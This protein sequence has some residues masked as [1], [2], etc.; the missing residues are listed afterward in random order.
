MGSKVILGNLLVFPIENALLYVEPLYIRAENG[1]LPELQ[2]V[3]AA[4]SDKI[5]MG[6]D[7]TSTLAA[8]F[9]APLETPSPTIAR[10]SSAA[11]QAVTVAGANG[12]AKPPVG[13][14]ATSPAPACIATAP[15]RRSGP[16]TGPSSGL[17]CSSSARNWAS[18]PIRLIISQSVCINQPARFARREGERGLPTDPMKRRVSEAQA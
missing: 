14:K 2:R 3:I 4:Y 1:Q 18:R 11:A 17:R 9:S 10:A 12:T 8:L 7:L 15:W 16:A 5:M 13:V 6:N